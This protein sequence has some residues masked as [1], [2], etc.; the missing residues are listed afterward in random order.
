MH[1]PH[2]PSSTVVVR[3]PNPFRD[4]LLGKLSDFLPIET[5]PPHIRDRLGLTSTPWTRFRMATLRA[6][7]PAA[8]RIL[9]KRL[10]YYPESYKAEKRLV[11]KR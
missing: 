7:A 11:A 8:F 9:P 2:D 3:P 1:A 10:T 5:V 4:R 6:T